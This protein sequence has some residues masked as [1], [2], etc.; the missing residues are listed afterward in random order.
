MP[1]TGVRIDSLLLRHKRPSPCAGVHPNKC[2]KKCIRESNAA[3]PSH[4]LYTPT[5]PIMHHP[6]LCQLSTEEFITTISPD[7]LL[8]HSLPLTFPTRCAD[9]RRTSPTPRPPFPLAD[10]LLT[11]YLDPQ[12]LSTALKPAARSSFPFAQH[13]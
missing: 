10:T 9:R 6:I 4:A 13:A 7:H 1:K 8:R 12:N 2:S 11:R 3:S 5:L